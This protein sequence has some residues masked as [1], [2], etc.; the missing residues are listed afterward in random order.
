MQDELGTMLRRGCVCSADG[1]LTNVPDERRVICCVV[2]TDIARL[3]LETFSEPDVV[4][5][6]T[7]SIQW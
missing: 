6:V 4:L 1:S 7:L 3:F 5:V 2:L